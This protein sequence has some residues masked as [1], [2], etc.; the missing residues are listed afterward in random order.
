MCGA[1]DCVCNLIANLNVVMVEESSRDDSEAVEACNTRLGEEGGHDV[2]QGTTDT[3]RCEDLQAALV[4]G[5][6]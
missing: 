1:T 5:N 2:S 4:R 3:V 6:G